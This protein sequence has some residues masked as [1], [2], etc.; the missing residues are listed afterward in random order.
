[1]VLC[2]RFRFTSSAARTSTRCGSGAGMKARRKRW[3]L[4]G[5]PSTSSTN[6]PRLSSATTRPCSISGPSGST[7]L[8]SRT[9]AASSKPDDGPFRAAGSS[10]LTSTCR[11]RSPL[12]ARSPRAGDTSATASTRR[13]AWPTISI[14]SATAAACPSSCV[15]PATRCMSTCGLRPPSSRFRRISIAG[16]ASTA[17][18]SRPTASPSG[19]I[20]PNTTT[21]RSGSAP[22]SSSR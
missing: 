11:A 16:A 17:R 4:S 7:R 6:T 22:A 12:S 1:M 3:Q 9:S 14:P 5:T 18:P 21:S 20:T 13:R 10:S 8:S 2:P 15:S 19:S